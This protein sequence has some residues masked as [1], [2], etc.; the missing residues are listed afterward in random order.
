MAARS[1][2]FLGLAAAFLL[3]LNLGGR[4][5]WEPDEPRH[6]AIAEEMRALRHGPAQLVLPRLNGEIY[7]QKPPLYYWLAALAGAPS[8]RVSEAAARV[9]SALAALAS[10]LLVAR[11]GRA[12]FGA[13]AGLAAAAVLATLPFQLEI[14]RSARPDALLELFVT[15]AL[16][17]AWRIDR[18]IGDAP[19]NRL[20]LH[21]AIALGVLSKGPVAAL[22]P[23]LGLFGYLGWERRLRDF[24]RFVSP[25]TAMLSVGVP[26]VWLG[27]AAALAPQG[28]LNQAVTVNLFGRFFAGTDHERAPLY[29]LGRLPYVFL[30]WT[31]AWPAAFVAARAALAAAPGSMCAHTV[32]FL[33]SFVASGLVF[34]SLSTGKR[35]V[36]LLPM[37]P[38]LALLVGLGLDRWLAG[39]S[40][41][42]RRVTAAAFAVVA[43][44]DLGVLAVYEPS[45]NPARSIHSAARAAA[46]LSPP[47]APIG[48]VRNGA[49]VGGVAYYSRRPV[50]R[51]GS[52]RGIERFLQSGGRVV[53]AEARDLSEIETL[54]PVQIAFRQSLEEDEMLVLVAP[55]TAA[56]ADGGP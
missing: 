36:Y 1:T 56:P 45:Q 41:T 12:S 54:A 51:L 52:R 20:A 39:R 3:L 26:L 25:A 50:D 6:G 21:A 55:R 34:F 33:V 38:A 17:F 8:G 11:L 30:P 14:G 35:T 43:A 44:V 42:L 2:G 49:L 9:P 29:Y 27:A 47:D 53:I 37:M 19:R 48:L 7:D 5:L 40:A 10:V 46:S 31:L 15:A 22:L 13:G 24:A 28:Y 32:R 23:L 18:G 4:D 16:L